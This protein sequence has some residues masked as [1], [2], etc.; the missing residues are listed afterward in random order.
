M[1]KWPYNLIDAVSPE[2][3]YEGSDNDLIP[4]IMYALYSLSGFERDVIRYKYEGDYSFSYISEVTGKSY[5]Y[6]IA[7]HT[8]ALRKL[9]TSNLSNIL[10][11]GVQGVFSRQLQKL[12]K[13]ID[14]VIPLDKLG[15]SIRYY[16][17]LYRA[18]IRTVNSVAQLSSNQLKYV[19]GLRAEQ[20][21]EIVSALKM[22]GYDVSHLS[23]QNNTSCSA[24]TKEG[25]VPIELL[26]LSLRWYN[27]LKRAK[28]DTVQQ[29]TNMDLPD[30][31]AIPNF[32][33][34]GRSE[35]LEKLKTNNY[36]I[37]KLEV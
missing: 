7:S 9:R 33:I 30:F 31:L 13:G 17:A 4:S 24:K 1:S 22:A 3:K 16:N 25:E 26:G 28:I 37:S 18:G 5:N 6:C 32:G 27:C 23:H 36:D 21:A 20:R 29:L 19:R 8:N 14:V 10:I 15:L 2:R 35:V 11:Y 34:K 12:G